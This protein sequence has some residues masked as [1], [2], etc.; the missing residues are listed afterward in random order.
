MYWVVEVLWI[1]KEYYCV[2]F[3]LN[4]LK[5]VVLNELVWGFDVFLDFCL[6]YRGYVFCVFEV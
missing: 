3:E 5:F 6:L 2:F 4:F 1:E